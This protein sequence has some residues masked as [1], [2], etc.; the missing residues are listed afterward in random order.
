MHNGN[1]P[2]YTENITLTLAADQKVLS[3]GDN[4]DFRSQ[5][6]IADAAATVEFGENKEFCDYIF[7]KIVGHA[8]DYGTEWKSD[9]VNH[10]QECTCG[11]RQNAAAHSGGTA[12]CTE[13]AKCT[14]CEQGYGALDGNNHPWESVS[15]VNDK[16]ELYTGNPYSNDQGIHTPTYICSHNK[17]HKK[18]ESSVP[19]TY[20]GNYEC[21]CGDK[22][23]FLI[24][25]DANGG[26]FYWI[27]SPIR[28]R[29]SWLSYGSPQYALVGH[30]YA[31][32]ADHVF[33]GWNTKA[34][35]SGDEWNDNLTVTGN[36]TYYAQ[37]EPNTLPIPPVS[38]QITFPTTA[39]TVTVY[40][41]EQ[42]MM[43]ITAENASAYQWF[44][45]YDGGRTW[46]EKPGETSASYT[47]SPTELS[48]SG[49]Q[50]KCRAYGSSTGDYVDSPIFTLEVLKMVV[51]PETGDSSQP[52]LWMALACLSLVGLTVVARKRKEA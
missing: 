18:T 6:T 24:T 11:E 32:R 10:W 46:Q 40:E 8:H 5:W 25:W 49:Y 51:L 37:W 43:S 41:G 31:Q 3:G 1:Q 20:D 16:N 42:A 15:Y 28:I 22:K 29:N 35:G 44:I 30:G 34:D 2:L 48:N 21:V 52:L 39:Q 45:S 33:A 7:K 47:T 14:I 19:H 26:S 12:T 36:V 13:Q 9:D 23:N 27:E 50:Y 38:P 4:T 17:D